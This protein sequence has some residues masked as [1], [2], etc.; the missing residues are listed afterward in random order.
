MSPCELVHFCVLML[1]NSRSEVIYFACAC[2]RQYTSDSVFGLDQTRL[3]VMTLRNFPYFPWT[4]C[5]FKWSVKCDF[6]TSTSFKIAFVSCKTLKKKKKKK[7][8]KCKTRQ[9][10]EKMHLCKIYTAQECLISKLYYVMDLVQ[11][12]H[13]NMALIAECSIWSAICVVWQPGTVSL[14]VP[15]LF[16]TCLL[17]CSNNNVKILVMC[18]SIIIT[19]Y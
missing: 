2:C 11:F 15:K 13:I 18:I 4:K 16:K 5:H 7:Y 1:Q 9:I 8:L 17:M 3:C 12:C 10:S 19:K 6:D 14:C